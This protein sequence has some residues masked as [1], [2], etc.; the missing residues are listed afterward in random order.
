VGYTGP[1]PPAKDPAHHYHF[2]VLALDTT[3]KIPAGSDRDAMLKA[4]KG[5]VIAKGETMA[6]FQAPKS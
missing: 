1:H 3:L 5:H 4:V 2:Q 6:T